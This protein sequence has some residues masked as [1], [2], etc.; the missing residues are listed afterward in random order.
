MG[1]VPAVPEATTDPVPEVTAASEQLEITTAELVVA[2][3]ALAAKEAA[4]KAEMEEGALHK[5]AMAQAWHETAAARAELAVRTAEVKR[6]ETTVETAMK[7]LDA[8]IAASNAAQASGVVVAKALVYALEG[9]RQRTGAGA[10]VGAGK[11]GKG[12][13]RRVVTH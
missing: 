2:R 1:R 13:E 8:A 3:R 12:G 5:E 11:G 4:L 7:G 10:G 9:P 6:L